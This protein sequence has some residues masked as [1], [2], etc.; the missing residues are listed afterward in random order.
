AIPLANYN[1]DVTTIT[2]NIPTS[3]PG[4]NAQT[5]SWT[6]NVGATTGSALPDLSTAMNITGPGASKLIVQA[7]ATGI[8]IFNVTTTGSVSISGL[9]MASGAT[10]DGGGGLA[11]SNGGAV[12][13]SNCTV[14]NNYNAG[15]WNPSGTMS[16]NNCTVSDNSSAGGG[17]DRK[18]TRL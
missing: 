18:S 17:G 10:T 12:N 5:H 7:G 11:N 14:R 6:I 9:T 8:R 4:Y 16:I 2:F 1:P 13:L 3:D 15:V